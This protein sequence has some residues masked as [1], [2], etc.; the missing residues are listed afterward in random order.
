MRSILRSVLLQKHQKP[1]LWN[2]NNTAI[3]VSQRGWIVKFK[4]LALGTDEIFVG[5]VVQF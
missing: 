5:K 3:Y 2:Y 4:S 1:C